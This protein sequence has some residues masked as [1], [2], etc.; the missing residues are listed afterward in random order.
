[1]KY[2]PICS[3]AV[4]V[5]SFCTPCTLLNAIGGTSVAMTDHMIDNPTMGTVKTDNLQLQ[6]R[7][8]STWARPS[9]HSS[10]TKYFNY[11]KQKGDPI[12]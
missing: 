11:S 12:R 3:Q 2:V 9:H 10:I 4:E 7:T 1:M 8:K 6:V 5:G